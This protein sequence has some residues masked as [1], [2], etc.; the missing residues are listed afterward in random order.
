VLLLAAF[1]V[2]ESRVA[3]APLV[4]LRLFRI[5][6]FTGTA[7]VAFAQSV[8]LYPMLLL[9]SVW[10]QQVLGYGPFETGLRVLPATIVL[11]LVA[12]FSG[13]LAGRVRLG[14]LLTAGLLVIG[15]ALLLL[16]AI[17]PGSDWTAALP[18]LVAV[19]IGVGII[20]PPLAA[21]MVGVLSSD[22]AGL[23]S[24]INNTF[25]QLGIAVGIAALGAVLE[26]HVDLVH[27]D[28]AGFAAGLDAAFL[29]AALV[30]FA[31]APLAWFLVRVGGQ[32]SATISNEI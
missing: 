32:S 3:K 24:G 25:R 19:G 4:D 21:A 11:L 23:A 8:A 13:R 2:F 20:S 12:P 14:I 18:G 9:L 29:I 17:G 28:A 22:R 5:G 7:I 6:S 16:R 15:V 1:V 10:M 31:A 26:S 30:A 27:P